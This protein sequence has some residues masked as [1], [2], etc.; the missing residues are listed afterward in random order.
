MHSGAYYDRTDL[1]T[2]FFTE[3]DA[4]AAEYRLSK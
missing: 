1:K 2:W 4:R 3:K